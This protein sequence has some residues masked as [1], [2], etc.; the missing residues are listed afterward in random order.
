VVRL[1]GSLRFCWRLLEEHDSRRGFV[2]HPAEPDRREGDGTSFTGTNGNLVKTGMDDDQRSCS[3]FWRRF[4]GDVGL[5]SL[6]VNL[7]IRSRLTVLASPKIAAC[8]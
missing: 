1:C 3:A 4:Q 8:Y 7:Q 6:P 2:G 5:T